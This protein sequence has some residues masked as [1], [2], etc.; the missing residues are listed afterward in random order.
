MPEA[1]A[2]EGPSH[3][4]RAPDIAAAA[5]PAPS[6]RAEVPKKKPSI[7]SSAAWRTPLVLD[8][9][10]ALQLQS[11]APQPGPLALDPQPTLTTIEPATLHLDPA[12]PYREATVSQSSGGGPLAPEPTESVGLGSGPPAL[13]SDVNEEVAEKP[14]EEAVDKP[15]GVF[16]PLEIMSELDLDAMLGI[17]PKTKRRA[18]KLAAKKAE[19]EPLDREPPPP[20]E[21]RPIQP[22]VLLQNQPVLKGSIPE[23]QKPAYTHRPVS[24]A[25][26]P[27][28]SETVFK[29]TESSGLPLGPTKKKVVFG[30]LLKNNPV[31]T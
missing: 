28:I 2:G 11:T 18:F 20:A 9:E 8:D 19:I 27:R 5:P 26:L 30:D 16:N 15:S 29:S 25:K 14:P 1:Q 13:L 6:S 21:S 31:A 3:A 7:Y 10:E 22:R 24:L 4:H 12:I 17:A 23:Q